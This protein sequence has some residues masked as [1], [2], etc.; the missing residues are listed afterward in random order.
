MWEEIAFRTFVPDL[1][2]ESGRTARAV[3]VRGEVDM[4]TAP[5]LTAKV[6]EEL[7]HSGRTVV[8]DLSGVTFFGVSGLASLL[9]ADSVARRTGKTLVLTAC[10]PAVLRMLTLTRTRN[11]F[12]GQASAPRVRILASS[13]HGAAGGLQPGPERHDGEPVSSL[14]SWS[15]PVPPA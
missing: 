13:S 5:A 14:L 10:S 15:C 1:V 11:W 3:A 2:D 8:L 9:E 4:G 7:S 12:A 6:T